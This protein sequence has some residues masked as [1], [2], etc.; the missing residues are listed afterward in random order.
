MGRQH[1][2]LARAGKVKNATPKWCCLSDWKKKKSGRSKKRETYNKRFSQ[3]G[4]PG[5][6]PQGMNKQT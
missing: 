6:W 5:V 1:G 3:Q 4:L 2:S